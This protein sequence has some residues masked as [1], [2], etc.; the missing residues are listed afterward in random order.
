[1]NLDAGNMECSNWIAATLY[2][3]LNVESRSGLRS[4]VETTT[5]AIFRWTRRSFIVHDVISILGKCQTIEDRLVP[6]WT[7]LLGN[8]TTGF[9]ET[10]NPSSAHDPTGDGTF[11][12]CV[13]RLNG[14]F[15]SLLWSFVRSFLHLGHHV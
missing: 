4:C 6:D 10:D 2:A 3:A 13:D 8:S 12:G 5:S 11:D 15:I 7:M 14:S 9:R 1:M